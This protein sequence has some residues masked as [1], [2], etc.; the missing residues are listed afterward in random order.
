[1]NHPL[2]SSRSSVT[3]LLLLLPLL[4][5]FSFAAGDDVTCLH[6]LKNSLQDPEGYLNSWDFSNTTEPGFICRFTG[7]FCWNAI[8]NRVL[9]LDLQDFSMKGKIPKSL[10]L[11]HSL[12]ILNLGGNSLSGDIPAQICTWLPYLVTLDLSHNSLSGSIPQNVANCTY[13]NSLV[14][15]DNK[16]S[17]SIPDELLKLQRLRK[18]S[19]ANNNL[20]GRIPPFRHDM[21]L[22]FSGNG[23]LCGWPLREC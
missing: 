20:S 15:D 7:V 16:L 3:A 17:G 10:H 5:A 14:L 22:N 13:L 11:C 18:F 19:A 9:G 8:E 6:E 2:L 1:M 4:S 12:Q 23:N 21:K